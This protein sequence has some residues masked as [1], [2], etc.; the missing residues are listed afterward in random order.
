V[1]I[2]YDNIENL[3]YKNDNSSRRITYS[4]HDYYGSRINV[5]VVCL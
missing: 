3:N 1:K 4:T 2:K 5:R